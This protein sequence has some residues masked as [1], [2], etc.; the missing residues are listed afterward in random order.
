MCTC[1]ATYALTASLPVSYRNVHDHAWSIQ[2]RKALET[3]LI[4]KPRDGGQETA[5]S[6]KTSYSKSCQVWAN[7]EYTLDTVFIHTPQSQS[8]R[9]NLFEGDEPALLAQLVERQTYN[10]EVW[11]ST[12]SGVGLVEGGPS[13][14]AA[15]GAIIN[16]SPEQ[17]AEPFNSCDQPRTRN[18]GGRI[19]P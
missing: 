15:V 4:V 9:R 11:G 5:P 16:A 13:V 1:E 2:Y 12:P 3:C 17:R 10:W 6:T 7:L 19:S 8:A 14:C 18:P